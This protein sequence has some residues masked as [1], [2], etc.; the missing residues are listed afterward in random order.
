MLKVNIPLLNYKAKCGNL[1]VKYGLVGAQV[2]CSLVFS[3][4]FIGF[5]RVEFDGE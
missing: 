1:E 4:S 5:Y 3:V 2:D